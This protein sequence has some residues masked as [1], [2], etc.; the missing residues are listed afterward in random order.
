MTQTEGT[1]DY[2]LSEDF[3]QLTT[4]F[5]SKVGLIFRVDSDSDQPSH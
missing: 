5:S 2:I 3:T 1:A 4:S